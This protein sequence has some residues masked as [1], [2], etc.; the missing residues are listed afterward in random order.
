MLHDDDGD[1]DDDDWKSAEELLLDVLI[2]K[3]LV[4]AAVLDML[5][6]RSLAC[7]RNDSHVRLPSMTLLLSL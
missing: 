2:I 6:L 7:S 4:D 5:S 1:D 3:S